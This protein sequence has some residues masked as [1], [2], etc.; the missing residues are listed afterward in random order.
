[1]PRNPAGNLKRAV[2]L[3]KFKGFD[4]PLDFGQ[5]LGSCRPIG[6]A[7]VKRQG[8]R[9]RELELTKDSNTL[10]EVLLD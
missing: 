9:C 2:A 10:P 5:E 4:A 7:V 8:E 3:G 6:D 1:M